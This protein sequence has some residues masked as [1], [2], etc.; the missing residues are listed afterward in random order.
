MYLMASFTLLK[1]FACSIQHNLGRLE[2][3]GLLSTP[4]CPFNLGC[5]AGSHSL[6][7]PLAWTPLPNELRIPGSGSLT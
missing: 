7:L 3:L 5:D 2:F 6:T 1:V 4:L